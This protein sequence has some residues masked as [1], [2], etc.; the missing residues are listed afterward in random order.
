[1]T[2]RLRPH[3]LLCLLTYVGKGYSAAF[4]ANYDAIAARIGD[5]EDVLIV[6][7]PDD[8]CAPLLGDADPHCHRDSVVERDRLALRDLGELLEA[9]PGLGERLA[10]E[11]ALLRQMRD[12][13]ATG[14]TRAACAGCEWHGLCTGI[15]ARGYAGTVIPSA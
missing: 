12:A 13:F 7:G 2:I 8:I 14:R 9:P 11:P 10:L 5:G 3:H 1:M 15:S 6:A 4:T